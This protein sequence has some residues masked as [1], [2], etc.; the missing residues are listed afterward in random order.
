M[1]QRSDLCVTHVSRKTTKGEQVLLLPTGWGGGE[2]GKVSLYEICR[3]MRKG[4][5]FFWLFWSKGRYALSVSLKVPMNLCIFGRLGLEKVN[6]LR[7]CSCSV[8][9]VYF[10]AV[11][12]I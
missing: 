6:V 9:F 8:L 4:M 5:L 11:K 2:G 12:T 7:E 1:V 10:R 3:C